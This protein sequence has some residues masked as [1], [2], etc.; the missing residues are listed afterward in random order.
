[1]PT[2]IRHSTHRFRAWFIA[3]AAMLFITSILEAGHVHGVFTPEDDHCTLC[4][5][6]IALDKTLLSSSCF[7]LPLLLTILAYIDYTHFTPALSHRFALI[8][9]PPQQL[10]HR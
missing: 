2:V 5:H 8:R 3:I 9:A 1:M 4:Q 6:S 10:Q 7:I